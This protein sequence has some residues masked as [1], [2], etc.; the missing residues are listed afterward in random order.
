MTNF[1][2]MQPVGKEDMVANSNNLPDKKKYSVG[3]VV[4]T[5]NGEKYIAD[6]LKSLYEQTRLPDVILVTDAGSDDNT[7]GI[8]KQFVGAAPNVEMRILTNEDAGATLGVVDNFEKGL[9][10]LDTDYIFFCDQDDVWKPQKIESV[11]NCMD[12]TN[13]A[14]CFS[15]ADV[16]NGSLQ[17]MGSSLWSSYGFCPEMNGEKHKLYLP[18]KKSSLFSQLLS[19][20]IVTGMTMCMRSSLKTI[21]LPFSKHGYHDAWISI[22]ASLFVNVVALNENLVLYRQHDANQEGANRAQKKKNLIQRREKVLERQLF[23]I[24]LKSRLVREGFPV[25]QA[26]VR[27]IEFEQKR[28]AMFSELRLPRKKEV[29]EYRNYYVKPRNV[30]VKD[31]I[32]ILY[33]ALRGLRGR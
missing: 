27:C 10:A 22:L 15:N 25:P 2:N 32:Y 5:Y 18:G 20:N 3:I 6:Q 12:A 7:V 24:D 9:N 31:C 8:C 28:F 17:Q 30:M 29:N 26:L 19:N 21:L 13:A 11:I 4:A 1:E 16:V 33:S 23:L 14:L